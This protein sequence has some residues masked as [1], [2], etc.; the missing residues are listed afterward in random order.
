[1]AVPSSLWPTFGAPTFSLGRLFRSRGPG[2]GAGVGPL[3]SPTT[4]TATTDED[5]QR[6]SGGGGGA[7]SSFSS[8]I[9]S[10]GSNKHVAFNEKVSHKGS[11]G[12]ERGPSS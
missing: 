1:M 10:P 3:T 12:S 9:P 4:T 6:G 8:S 2:N 5:D 7:S 11:I